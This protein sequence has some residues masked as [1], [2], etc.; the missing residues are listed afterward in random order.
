MNIP[1]SWTS[2]AAS[3]ATTKLATRATLPSKP[4][5]KR[6]CTMVQASTNALSPGTTCAHQAAPTWLAAMPSRDEAIRQLAYRLYTLCERAGRAEDAR[7][8]NELITAWPGI[9]SAASAAGR[10]GT[11]QKLDL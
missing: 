8:Y 3:A 9:E 2:G 4:R 5:A 10:T 6:C 11:Q 7:F 1:N